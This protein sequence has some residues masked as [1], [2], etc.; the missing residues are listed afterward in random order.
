M[1]LYMYGLSDMPDLSQTLL[2]K[3]IYWN[4]KKKKSTKHLVC[5]PFIWAVD[6]CDCLLLQSMWNSN[7][8]MYNFK[9]ATFNN[10]C[11][12]NIKKICVTKNNIKKNTDQS[13]IYRKG[14]GQQ[15]Q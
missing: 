2:L 8:R 7:V 11:V 10:I 4:I 15:L 13:L 6:Y 12:Y 3:Q 5:N 14:R 9:F 1:G